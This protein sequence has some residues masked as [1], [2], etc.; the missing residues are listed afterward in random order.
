MANMII[1]AAT[2]CSLSVLR[3]EDYERCCQCFPTEIRA[4]LAFNY[5]RIIRGDRFPNS[6]K[7]KWRTNGLSEFNFVEKHCM[8]KV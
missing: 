8:E 1:I 6:Q 3:T 4:Q 2:D 5:R 7:V